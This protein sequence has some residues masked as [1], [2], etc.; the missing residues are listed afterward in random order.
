MDKNSSEINIPSTVQDPHYRYKMPR[1]QV[2]HQGSGN[3]VKTKWINLAEITNALKVP[4]EYPLKFIGKELGSNTEIKV[5]SYLINGNH[6]AEKM[7]EI[8]DKFIK[9]YVL[10]PKCKLPEIHGKIIVKKGKSDIKCICRSCGT[11]SK[12]DST[13]DFASY[14][15]RSPPPFEEDD[16]NAKENT[17]TKKTEKK[18]V[19]EKKVRIKIKEC[20]ENLPKIIKPDVD[21]KTNI[22]NIKKLYEQYNFTNDIKFYVFANGIFDGKLYTKTFEKRLPIIKHFILNENGGKLN[23]CL[24]NFLIGL[25]DFVF[26]RQN[27]ENSKYL[28]SILY[29]L[30]MDD[31][32]T[33]DF[34]SDFAITKKLNLNSIF[35]IPDV[36]S[37]FMHAVEDFTKWIEK[38]P[39]E[40]EEVKEEDIDIDN[41]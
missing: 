26:A 3:G 6:T 10:C 19:I 31:I 8:L 11:L 21:D 14:I 13:H 2:A 27:G 29:Y 20:V 34:W 35:Y 41:I 38:G 37:K 22:E 32:V 1:I 28:S 40:G 4:I 7:Q 16:P 23:E 39:R 24:F 36:E 12:L 9:K 17:N 18:N 25:A 33:E 30:Y 15:K 5:N